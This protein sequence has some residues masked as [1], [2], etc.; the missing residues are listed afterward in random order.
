MLTKQ[1]LPKLLPSFILYYITPGK[2]PCFRLNYVYPS[3]SSGKLYPIVNKISLTAIP[4]HR[5]HYL[6]TIHFTAAHSSIAGIW[7]YPPPHP[8]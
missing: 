7:E 3:R 4:Y 2:E 6:K 5:L 1:Y 8:E